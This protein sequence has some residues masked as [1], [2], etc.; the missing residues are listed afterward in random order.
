[1]RRARSPRSACRHARRHWERRVG[2][3]RRRRRG[4]SSAPCRSGDRSGFAIVALPGRERP[5]RQPPQ[6]RRFRGGA[7]L[8]PRYCAGRTQRRAGSRHRLSPVPLPP[9]QPPRAAAPDGWPGPDHREA[10]RRRRGPKTASRRT[11]TGQPGGSVGRPATS[12]MP[13]RRGAAGRP[14]RPSSVARRLLKPP[15]QGREAAARERSRSPRT[16]TIPST[17]G[18]PPMKISAVI[19]C[20]RDA[21]A[22]PIMHERLVDAFARAGRRL[23]DHLRQRRL[24]RQRARGARRA[25]GARPQG[26]RRQPRAGVRLAERV[27]LRDADRDRRRRGPARRRPPGPAGGDPQLRREMARG[28]RRRLR[29]ARPARGAPAHADR[30]TRPSTA[31]SGDSPMSTSPSTRATSA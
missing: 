14:S 5:G 29:R 12:P 25:G 27:H 7:D 30:S 13:C 19:A 8:R 26:R 20:Y 4:R 1:M 31:C 2:W 9:E 23:R 11:L 10:P 22:V 3:S 16:A 18:S 6:Q 24:A 17:V 21:P 28:L 15:A